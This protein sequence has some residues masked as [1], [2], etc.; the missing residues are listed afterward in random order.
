MDLDNYFV[1]TW[2]SLTNWPTLL[3]FQKKA[4]K[5]VTNLTN[6]DAA[7]GSSENLLL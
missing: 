7:A 6:R 3:C 4:R 2:H 5:W 1:I